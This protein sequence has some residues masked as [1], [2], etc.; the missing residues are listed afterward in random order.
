MPVKLGVERTLV[1]DLLAIGMVWSLVF[2]GLWGLQHLGY[3]VGYRVWPTGEDRNWISFL[4]NG[5]GAAAARLFWQMNDRNPLSPWWYI[6]VRTIIL[7]WNAG[8]LLVAYAVRLLLAVSIYLCLRGVAGPGARRFALAVACLAAATSFNG[9]IDNIIW[10]FVGA[11]SL[12]L[13]CVWAFTRFLEGGPKARDWYALSLVLWFFAFASYTL[14]SGGVLAIGVL[15]LTHPSSDRGRTVVGA[16][17]RRIARALSHTWPFLALYAGFLLIWRTTSNPNMA[18]YYQTSFSFRQFLTSVRIG[19]WHADYSTFLAWLIGGPFHGMDRAVT[20]GV[21]FLCSFVILA[22]AQGRPESGNGTGRLIDFRGILRI[23]AVAVCIAVPTVMVEASSD[24]WT[25]GLRWRMLHP[26]WI[27]LVVSTLLAA[28]ALAGSALFARRND[29]SAMALGAMAW[30]CLVAAGI[31]CAFL[32]DV[33]HNQIQVASTRREMA[34]RQA[35]A[36]IVKAQG[37]GAQDGITHFLIRRRPG[38]GWTSS[39]ALS[40]TYISTWFPDRKLTLRVIPDQPPPD[41]DWKGW[42]TVSFGDDGAGVQNLAVDGSQAPYATVAVLDLDAADHVTL[43]SNATKADFDGLAVAWN[44]EGPLPSPLSTEHSCGGAWT[45][46]KAKGGTGFSVPE[47]DDTGPFRWTVARTASIVVVPCS[48][49]MRIK[50]EVA[51]AVTE[52]NLSGLRI[53]LSG[54]PLHLQAEHDASGT[55]LEGHVDGMESAE[56]KPVDLSLE[57]PKLDTV[58]GADRQFGVAVRSISVEPEEKPSQ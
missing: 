46:A 53:A 43:L 49:P 15:S 38:V 8:L 39:D 3:P 27:P 51:F 6:A 5:P 45:A 50:V 1:I 36:D 52:E 31:A 17:G 11:L 33:G 19:L 48:G 14:Q 10:N 30:G 23:C 35:I 2:L 9:Y 7:G 24:V 28:V 56:G 32:I 37:D 25:P 12:T 21:V 4:Q 44:R 40:Q 29:H 54:R 26:F 47:K 34:V 18:A 20:A 22:V 13:L 42:W 16:A 57:V 55:V 41:P 58:S